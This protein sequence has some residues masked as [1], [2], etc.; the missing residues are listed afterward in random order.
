LWTQLYKHNYEDTQVL[1]HNLGLSD[2][3][4]DELVAA[5]HDPQAVADV[6]RW[7]DQNEYKRFQAAP[8]LKVTP[9]AFG[10]GR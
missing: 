6:I 5:G 9:K 4:P 2:T 10:E 3:G 1:T 8:G 7:V